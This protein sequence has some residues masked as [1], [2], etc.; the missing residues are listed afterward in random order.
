MSHALEHADADQP[1]TR[2]TFGAYLWFVGIVGLW[3]AFG[4]VALTSVE[5]LHDLW[6]WVTGLPIIGEVVVWI[7]AFPGF[8]V[9]GSPRPHGRSR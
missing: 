4:L 8:S 3:M 6:E 7:A 1:S 9:S 5:K 2:P